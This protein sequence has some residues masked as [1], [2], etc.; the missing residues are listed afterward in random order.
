MISWVMVGAL[1]R[2]WSKRNYTYL[3]LVSKIVKNCGS[4]E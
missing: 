3:C 1:F 2:R 4:V